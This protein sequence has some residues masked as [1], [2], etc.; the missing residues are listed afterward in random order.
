MNLSL[1]DIYQNETDPDLFLKRL[2]EYRRRKMEEIVGGIILLAL[3]AVT[4]T[5]AQVAFCIW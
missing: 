5:I 4:L 2:R 1:E 3:L